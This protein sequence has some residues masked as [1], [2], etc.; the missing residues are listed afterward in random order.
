MISVLR[1]QYRYLGFRLI[2]QLGAPPL[3]A[4]LASPS[5]L[6]PTI[7]HALGMEH[8]RLY[9]SGGSRGGNAGCA[10]LQ[11]PFLSLVL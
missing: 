7:C 1:I 3:V 4:I 5:S 11:P 8:N 6:A 9:L 10:S 2:S